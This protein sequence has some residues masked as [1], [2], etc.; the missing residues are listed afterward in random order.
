V[1]RDIPPSEAFDASYGVWGPSGEFIY[2]THS[3][4]LGSNPDPGKVDQ[5]WRVDVDDTD[6]RRMIHT[7]RIL[8]ADISPDGQWFVFHSF[9]VP[10][11]LYKMR[12]DGTALQRLTGPDSPNPE[13]EYT[14]LGRWSPI[15]NK[16]LFSVSAGEPRGI[17]LMDSSGTNPHIIIPYGIDAKWFPE[18]DKV[19]YL[20][21]DTTQVSTKQQ[22]IYIANADGTNPQKI[23]NLTHS[24]YMGDIAEPVVSP[25]G[26]MIAFTHLGRDGIDR[27]IFIMNVDGSGVEQ[28][29]EG[30]GYAARPEWSPD[31]KTILFSRIIPNESKRLYY[32][33]VATREVT[34]VFPE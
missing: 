31:G 32:L 4:E 8:N 28:I 14:G 16:I 6:N 5:L 30:P 21:W 22:Q 29:T 23:T 34:P 1:D 13:W 24:R 25:D 20:N 33:D 10:S 7:G 27:E 18:G 11:Y 19:I 15:G 17:A 26:E 12:S 2:F 3:E 9:S